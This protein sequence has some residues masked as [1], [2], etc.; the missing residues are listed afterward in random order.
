M[1]LR[2]KRAC[3]SSAFYYVASKIQSELVTSLIALVS[4]EL[5]GSLPLSC[6]GLPSSMRREAPMNELGSYKSLHGFLD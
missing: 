3:H 6:F 1:A 5:I 2:A 4:R